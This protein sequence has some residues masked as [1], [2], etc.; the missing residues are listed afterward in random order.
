MLDSAF[1]PVGWLALY[2]NRQ[3]LEDPNHFGKAMLDPVMADPRWQ[4]GKTP[5]IIFY[6][7]HGLDVP[8]DRIEDG[9]RALSSYR[10]AWV[11]ILAADPS[12]YEIMRTCASFMRTFGVLCGVHTRL[13]DFYDWIAANANPSF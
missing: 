6:N 7:S 12:S 13:Q 9:A 1:N 2:V 4:P 5:I 3:A 10:P 11:N 8:F